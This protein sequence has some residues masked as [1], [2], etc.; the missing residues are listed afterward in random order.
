M[1]QKAHIQPTR[2]LLPL[3]QLGQAPVVTPPRT[4]APLPPVP[5]SRR[6][7][8]RKMKPNE[9]FSGKLL[10]N[11]TAVLR[12]TQCLAFSLLSP[13]SV[14]LCQGGGWHRCRA[15]YGARHPFRG[16][17]STPHSSP[18]RP[19]RAHRK[20][21]EERSP[22]GAETGWGLLAPRPHPVLLLLD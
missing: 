5:Q 16:R 17:F 6:S 2:T 14:L 22:F 8:N 7:A 18:F 19:W 1:K 20:K 10:S 3:R 11:Y 21:T 9:T 12:Y 4:P 15:F 13:A